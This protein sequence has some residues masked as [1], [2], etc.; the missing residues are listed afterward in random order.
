MY[1]KCVMFFVDEAIEISSMQH[2]VAPKKIPRI[3]TFLMLAEDIVSPIKEG[4]IQQHKSTALHK[5]LYDTVDN[6]A[7][8]EMRRKDDLKNS[9]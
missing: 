7:E 8:R 5:S 6:R 1:V 9:R 4:I 2:S 3:S